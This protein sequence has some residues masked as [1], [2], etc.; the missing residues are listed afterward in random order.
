MSVISQYFDSYEISALCA[1]A[2]R[3]HLEIV[4]RL[5]NAG[6]KANIC[7]DQ[8]H[9]AL[10]A[11]SRAGHLAVV[12]MLLSC[13]ANVNDTQF[14]KAV[15]GA[16]SE[17]YV[18]VLRSLLKATRM[19]EPLRY[20]SAVFGTASHSRREIV[21]FLLYESVIKDSDDKVL[22]KLALQAASLK[23]DTELMDLLS[24]NGV[25]ETGCDENSRA[26]FLAVQRGF[27]EIVKVLINHDIYGDAAR[28]VSDDLS[29]SEYGAIDNEPAG[30]IRRLWS[31]DMVV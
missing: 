9:G 2:G 19:V 28:D 16:S 31:G 4:Q 15:E 12:D 13:G 20:C 14:F 8:G 23:G 17:G 25:G 5:I 29:E 27:D 26:L 1:A 6:A 18:D 11:S 22:A 24:E 7:C 3:G 10:E 21:H 30:S